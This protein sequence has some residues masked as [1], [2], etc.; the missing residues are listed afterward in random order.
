MDVAA[1][2]TALAVIEVAKARSKIVILNGPGAT[3]ITNKACSPVSIHYTF[4]N[5]A[6]SHGTGAAILK[7]GYDT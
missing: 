5:Y 1:S 2:A 4:D 6:V 7:E 3:R